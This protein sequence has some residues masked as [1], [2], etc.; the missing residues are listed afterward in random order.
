[1]GALSLGSTGPTHALQD[2]STE[3]HPIVGTWIAD[4]DTADPTF[5]LEIFI[6]TADGG[7]IEGDP[8]D[9]TLGAWEATGASSA[10]YDR[11]VL[12]DAWTE[13]ARMG[14]VGASL[15]SVS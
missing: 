7:F 8:E 13:R 15:E 12:G 1:M 9:L 4:T 11:L 10:A 2:D 6:F 3:I 5:G 14:G